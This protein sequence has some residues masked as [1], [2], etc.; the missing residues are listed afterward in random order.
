MMPCHCYVAFD[1]FSFFRD[2][3]AIDFRRCFDACFSFPLSLPPGCYRLSFSPLAF[4]PPHVIFREDISPA[5]FASYA[6]LSSITL[7]PPRIDTSYA[8]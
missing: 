6:R 3:F 4:S 5:F 7:M 8:A 2:A 1:F